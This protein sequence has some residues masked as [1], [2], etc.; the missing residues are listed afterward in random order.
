MNQKKEVKNLLIQ[1]SVDSGLAVNNKIIHLAA[2]IVADTKIS[3]KI[4]EVT[5]TVEIKIYATFITK[6]YSC[7]RSSSTLFLVSLRS[8][9]VSPLAATGNTAKNIH[10]GQHGVTV[11]TYHIVNFMRKMHEAHCKLP[12][13]S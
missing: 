7:F 2:A 13:F 4:Q 3:I 8:G 9:S 11:I 12:T 1:K 6:G 10:Y 5:I